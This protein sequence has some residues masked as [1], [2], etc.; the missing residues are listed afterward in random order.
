RLTT[1][2]R[3][4]QQTQPILVFQI[5]LSELE[6]DILQQ[7]EIYAQMRRTLSELMEFYYV[8]QKVDAFFEVHMEDDAM[9]E[10]SAAELE[11]AVCYFK[12]FHV[13]LRLFIYLVHMT[14]RCTS[15]TSFNYE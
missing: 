11:E 7:N 5:Q 4:F 6:R 2:N 8:L 15:A 10:F 12:R 13:W 9:N 14:V 3:C 1:A